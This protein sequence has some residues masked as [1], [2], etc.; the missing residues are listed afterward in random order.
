V[1]KVFEVIEPAEDILI[2]FK[3]LEGELSLTELII[4]D[5]VDDVEGTVLFVEGLQLF[6][7]NRESLYFFEN[8]INLVVQV[9][10]GFSL[11]NTQLNLLFFE[12]EI[13]LVIQVLKG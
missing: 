1:F 10:K 8:E 3:H 13:N 11:L 4:E 9:L 7:M 12:N 5:P 6:Q 2:S